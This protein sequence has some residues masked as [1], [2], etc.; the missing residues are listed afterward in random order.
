MSRRRP[1]AERRRHRRHPLPCQVRFTDAQGRVQAEGKS[2]NISD[3]GLLASVPLAE[4]PRRNSRT[5]LHVS[6]PRY[7]T[8][9]FM[10]EDVECEGTI[11]RHAPLQDD[12]FAGVAVRFRQPVRLQ[13]E[14]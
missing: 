7:T 6:V 5:R 12:R 9:T 4:I 3:G 8:N 2:L 1:A 14:A 10:L 11:V 13:I